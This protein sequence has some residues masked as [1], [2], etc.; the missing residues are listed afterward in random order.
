MKHPPGLFITFEGCEGCGKST[1]AKLLSSKLKTH[2]VPSL[3][4]Q[5]PGGTPLGE[6]VRDILKTRSDFNISPLSELF[7]FS[8]CRA[9]LI[10][11]V[12]SPALN[13]GRVVVCD[14]FTDSTV[15]YQGYG[16]GLDLDLIKHTNATATGGLIP[17]VTILLDTQPEIGLQRKHFREE[18]RFETEDISF[19][20]KIRKGYL[21]LARKE[22]D[23]WLVV[24]SGKPIAQVSA[25]IWKHLL[26]RIKSRYPL[27][28]DL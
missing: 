17:D 12:I 14:R 11:D 19:H 1:Q 15:V 23:R 8:A 5:E 13:S 24:E 2:K 9:Q 4:T 3:L 16:R 18:D 7:L 6:M 10:T 21:E 25:I 28:S 26:P 20:S 22:P 27:A